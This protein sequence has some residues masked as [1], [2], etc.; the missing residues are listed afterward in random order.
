MLLEVF[1]VFAHAEAG[2]V[3]VIVVEQDPH[4]LKGFRFVIG[5]MSGETRLIT[6]AP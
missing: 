2:A 3:V 4:V 5:A 6:Q 1:L